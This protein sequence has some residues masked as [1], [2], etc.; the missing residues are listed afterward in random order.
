MCCYGKNSQ[1]FHES[2]YIAGY[3]FFSLC[4]LTHYM[5]FLMKL[6]MCLKMYFYFFMKGFIFNEIKNVFLL[7]YVFS[8]L[9]ITLLLQI[10]YCLHLWL[11]LYKIVKLWTLASGYLGLD[12]GLSPTDWTVTYVSDS[13]CMRQR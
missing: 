6:K 11:Q 2:D 5:Y 4:I 12:L 10:I 3:C 9:S 13:L 8:P 1:I 7:L